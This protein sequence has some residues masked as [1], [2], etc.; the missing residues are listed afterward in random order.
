[1]RPLSRWRLPSEA[2]PSL[3]AVPR[4]RG[5]CLLA[6]APRV[7]LS[8]VPRKRGPPGGVVRGSRPQGFEPPT[9]PLQTL[10]R[11]RRGVARCSLGLLSPLWGDVCP[12]AARSEE[13]AAALRRG[14][15]EGGPL[16][17][18][19]R[20]SR[21]TPPP[22]RGSPGLGRSAVGAPRSAWAGRPGRLCSPGP[23]RRSGVCRGAAPLLAWASEEVRVCRGAGESARR[24]PR[25]PPKR[26]GLGSRLQT[27]A[28]K[29]RALGLPLPGRSAPGLRRALALAC[30]WAGSAAPKSCGRVWRRFLSPGGVLPTRGSGC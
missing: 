3:A 22:R 29:R 14:L 18:G 1:V 17:G 25:R 15:P 28:P 11:C 23:P 7:C 27:F 26:V 10:W 19:A 24:A 6:V 12:L 21:R 13:R 9:S 4:H 2:F 8:G 30:R 16:W 5:L 20:T